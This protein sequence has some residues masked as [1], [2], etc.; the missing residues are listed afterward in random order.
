MSSLVEAQELP[1]LRAH[2]KA[3]PMQLN[4]LPVMLYEE[5]RSMAYGR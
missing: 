1:G 3:L 2:A 5:P 4:W